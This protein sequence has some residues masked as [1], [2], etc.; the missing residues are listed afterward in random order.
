[1]HTTADP[2][3][4]TTSAVRIQR[5]CDCGTGTSEEKLGVQPKLTVGAPDDAY[6]QEADRVADRVI[7]GRD[8]GAISGIDSSGAVQRQEGQEEEEELQ[9]QRKGAD[10]EEELNMKAAPGSAR[11]APG[12]SFSQRLASSARSG[13]TLDAATRTSFEPHFG[14]DLSSVRLHDDSASQSLS[15]EINARAF[16][17]GNDI[18]FAAGQLDQGSTEGRRLLAHEITHTLQQGRNTKLRRTVGNNATCPANAHNAPAKPLDALKKLDARASQLALGTSNS[19]FLESVTFNDPI[20]QHPPTFNAYKERFGSAPKQGSRWRSRLRGK[21]FKT[22]NEAIAD[23]LDSVSDNFSRIGRWFEGSIRYR[24]PGT[25]TYK[26]PGCADAK[27]GTNLAQSCPGS[28]TMG[29]CPGFWNMSSDDSRAAVLI[30]EAVHAR[31]R[32]RGHSTANLNRRIRNPECYEAV[33]S[34][35]HGLKLTSFTCPKV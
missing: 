22:E 9:L 8:V 7:A 17:H 20:L 1:M 28:R 29:V 25:S 24:C 13:R 10:G 2:I 34:D 27:C 11:R 3:N 31:L 26:I 16:T 6:E 12:Q 19:L 32:F 14:R 15:R 30:H 33:V 18:Y 23:E 4:V 35:V 5:A 21:T